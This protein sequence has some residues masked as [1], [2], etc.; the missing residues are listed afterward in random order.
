[1]ISTVLE[2]SQN[3][4][5]KSGVPI[6]CVQHRERGLY[7]LETGRQPAVSPDRLKVRADPAQTVMHSGLPSRLWNSGRSRASP[8]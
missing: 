1:M 6:N 7:A 3:V 2:K 5:E 8:F 4:F